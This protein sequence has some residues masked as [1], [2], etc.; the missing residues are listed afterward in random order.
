MR[1]PLPR[2][3][4]LDAALVARALAVALAVASPAAAQ[5]TPPAPA[6]AP[7]DSVTADAM[8]RR[9]VENAGAVNTAPYTAAKLT[10]RDAWARPA[11][12]GATGAAYLTLDNVGALPIRIVGLSSPVARAVEAHETTQHDG[13]AHMRMLP[14]LQVPA[15]GRLQMRPGGLHLMLVEL[16]RPLAVG[17]AVP[18]TLRT[19][20]GAT[21]ALTARVRAP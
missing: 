1:R 7:L 12:K 5:R 19:A 4:A 20:D 21:I 3:H 17:D 15:R 14:A 8:R 16:A 11:R 6:P 10:A 9:A 2:S 13:M 18:L